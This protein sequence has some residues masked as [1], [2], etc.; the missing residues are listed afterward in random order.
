MCHGGIGNNNYNLIPIAGEATI[1]KK[2]ADYNNSVNLIPHA[3]EPKIYGRIARSEMYGMFS[4]AGLLGFCNSSGTLPDN[5]KYKYSL[6][7]YQNGTCKYYDL[8]ESQTGLQALIYALLN[9]LYKNPIIFRTFCASF[10]SLVLTSWFVWLCGYFGFLTSLWIM[11]G[12][13]SFRGLMLFGDNIAHVLGASYLI[14]IALFW[15]YKKKVKNVGTVT[16]FVLLLKLLLNGPEYLFSAF[17]LPFLPLVFYSVL[18][19]MT[20]QR[21]KKDALLITGGIV[22][23]CLVALLIL[24]I[25][26]SIARSL[27]EAIHHSIN[28]VMARTYFA[29]PSSSFATKD[30]LKNISLWQLLHLYLCFPCINIGW[31]QVSFKMIIL[32]FFTTSILTFYIYRCNQQRILLALLVT[33]WASILCPLSW[34]LIAKGHSAVHTYIDQFI[35]HMPFTLLGMA[36]T[37]VTLH[38]YF[39]KWWPE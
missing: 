19:K 23:A 32:F 2:V 18:Y 14:M 28:R 30:V 35:W 8:Y 7:C 25:Q 20:S 17:L 10:L 33:T 36:L 37:I 13:L 11:L 31:F 27:P 16:F 24:M 29:T 38:A 15:A 4:D 22:L 26:I 39:K 9:K 34:I 12:I 1:Y 3:G 5:A 21:I 6:S